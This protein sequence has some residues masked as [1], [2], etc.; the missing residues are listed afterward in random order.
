V[1]LEQFAK[2]AGV[3]LTDCAPEWGGRIGYKT[4][5]T[6][7]C[8]TCGFR[9]ADAAYKGW[10]ED[11]FGKHTAKAVIKLLKPSPRAK[12]IDHA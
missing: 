10:L 4:K 2:S 1:N 5:D 12:E 8:T 9:T 11:T 6:P 7:N 3:E